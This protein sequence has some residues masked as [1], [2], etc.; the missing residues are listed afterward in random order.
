MF[1]RLKYTFLK[2]LNSIFSVRNIYKFKCKEEVTDSNFINLFNDVLTEHYNEADSYRCISEDMQKLDVEKRQALVIAKKVIRKY[3]V[4]DR[5]DLR[6]YLSCI[7]DD[8]EYYHDAYC[9]NEDDCNVGMG[10]ETLS[11]IMYKLTVIRDAY[12]RQV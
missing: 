9:V 2:H 3:I 4:D 11:D 12:A 1:R 7:I 8:F 6:K 5:V 10:K